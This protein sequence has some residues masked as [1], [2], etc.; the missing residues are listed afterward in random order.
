MPTLWRSCAVQKKLPQLP[1]HKSR[2]T[3]PDTKRSR[4][5][6]DNRLTSSNETFVNAI[7]SSKIVAALTLILEREH[8]G[9]HLQESRL[10][11]N[12]MLPKPK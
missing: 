11:L 6:C 8:N 7:S 9:Q 12:L 5:T 3:R 2:A 1:R 10:E 4:Q